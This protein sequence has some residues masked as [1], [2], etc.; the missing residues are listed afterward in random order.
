MYK[1]SLRDLQEPETEVTGGRERGPEQTV[2]LLV[3]KA[4]PWSM[5]PISNSQLGNMLAKVAEPS[6]AMYH[7]ELPIA[8]LCLC[9]ALP[10]TF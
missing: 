9:R 2:G 5:L 3:D 4:S 10:L 8:L 1:A 7:T 6:M